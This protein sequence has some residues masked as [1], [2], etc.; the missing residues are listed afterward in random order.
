MVFGRAGL[1][2]PATSSRGFLGLCDSLTN[3]SPS[4]FPTRLSSS[5]L[6]TPKRS[7]GVRSMTRGSNN[8]GQWFALD[9]RVLRSGWLTSERGLCN[10]PARSR[11]VI[12]IDAAGYLSVRPASCSNL[13][14]RCSNFSTSI[15]ISTSRSDLVGLA[16][17]VGDL[18]N[19]LS[20]E[21][22]DVESAVLLSSVLPLLVSKKG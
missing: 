1:I 7:S 4:D 12:L 2:T 17:N 21:A 14:I 9:A 3:F 10:N 20:W 15:S 8:T 13:I 6:Y 19:T 22:T 16:S 11:R 5:V 18:G